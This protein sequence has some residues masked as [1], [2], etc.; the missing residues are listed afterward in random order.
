[1]SFCLKAG[2]VEPAEPGSTLADSRAFSFA[3]LRSSGLVAR[4][5]DRAPASLGSPVRSVKSPSDCSPGSSSTRSKRRS[6][7][8]REIGFHGDCLV[9]R[10]I[11]P[12]KPG[13]CQRLV[14]LAPLF[15][16]RSGAR[17]FGLF[18]MNVRT[19]ATLIQVA[20]ACKARPVTSDSASQ[21]TGYRKSN[22][23]GNAHGEVV[24]LGRKSRAF[25][26]SAS[27]PVPD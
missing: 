22:C 26:I 12:A 25:R 24:V 27:R 9:R 13:S 11:E 2:R 19:G 16:L 18:G 1:V 10:R 17:D 8:H 15:G 20:S 6:R 4:P 7:R 5:Q 21:P 3:H 14:S 23:C